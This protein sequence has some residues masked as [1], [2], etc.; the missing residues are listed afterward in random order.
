M[1]YGCLADSMKE[2]FSDYQKFDFIMRCINLGIVDVVNIKREKMIEFTKVY[3]DTMARLNTD[4]ERKAASSYI[5]DVFNDEIRQGGNDT[6]SDFIFN[7]IYNILKS[8]NPALESSP[9]FMTLVNLLK[10]VYG[11]SK[12][13]A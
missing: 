12:E 4:I 6:M 8:D 1:S 7:Q 11:I 10:D 13:E 5:R 2:K 3:L 9:D